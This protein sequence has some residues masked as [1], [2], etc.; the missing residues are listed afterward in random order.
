MASIPLELFARC[1]LGVAVDQMDACE[2]VARRE[3][4]AIAVPD[5]NSVAASAPAG[6][7]WDH[8][9]RVLILCG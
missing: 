5:P 3:R 4:A 7:A 2:D 8:A 6:G 9:Q 1:H